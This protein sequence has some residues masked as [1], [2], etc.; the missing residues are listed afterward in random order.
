MKVLCVM[1]RVQDIVWY[2]LVLV[3]VWKTDEQ[4]YER[5]SVQRA[6]VS[7][8]LPIAVNCHITLQTSGLIPRTHMYSDLVVASH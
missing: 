2:S 5:L 3:C 6:T 8:A 4:R 7:L 1:R